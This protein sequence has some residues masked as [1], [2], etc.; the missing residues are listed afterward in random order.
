MRERFAQRL[1]PQRCEAVEILI[2]R[3]DA[4]VAR[5]AVAVASDH[6]QIERQADVLLIDTGA[7]ISANVLAFT[8]AA[9]HVLVVTTP[10]PTAITDA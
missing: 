9:D 4:D 2:V 6:D 10:E 7:G 8:R 1:A 3:V 5:N